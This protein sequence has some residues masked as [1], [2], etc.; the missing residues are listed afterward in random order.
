MSGKEVVYVSTSGVK[1]E[2]DR[3]A[4]TLTV[5]TQGD[6]T[7]NVDLVSGCVEIRSAGDVCLVTGGRIAFDAAE[8]VDIRTGGDLSLAAE[9]ET[10][11]RGKMVRI[12]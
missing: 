9:G 6:N 7:L 10:I 12:N 11:I 2:L 4:E 3:D 8:G 5:R 1:L